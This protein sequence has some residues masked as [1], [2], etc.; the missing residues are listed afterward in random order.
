MAFSG[1]DPPSL[2]ALL[3]PI[4]IEEIDPA[5]HPPSFVFHGIG[6]TGSGLVGG[7][8]QDNDSFSILEG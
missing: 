8:G 4:G 1:I 7:H 3:K 2:Q 6:R 5:L